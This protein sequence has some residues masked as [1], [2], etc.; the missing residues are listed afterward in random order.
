MALP[1]DDIQQIDEQDAQK[2]NQ[3]V[4][5]EELKVAVFQME[6]IKAPGLPY[7]YGGVIAGAKRRAM[8]ACI[9]LGLF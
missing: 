4:Q 9:P 8:H 6:H 1:L 7:G 5:H 2:S 3:G